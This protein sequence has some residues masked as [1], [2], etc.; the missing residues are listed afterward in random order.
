MARKGSLA[1]LGAEKFIN[2][3]SPPVLNY[4]V[5]RRM[6]EA[7]AST[8]SMARTWGVTE[9]TM[10]KWDAQDDKDRAKLASTTMV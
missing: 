4:K 1:D 5:Y 3:N 6:R 2:L 9:N 8:A 10:R 7:K